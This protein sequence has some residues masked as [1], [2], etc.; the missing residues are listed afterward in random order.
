MLI[1][2]H[3]QRG[4]AA[5]ESADSSLEALASLGAVRTWLGEAETQAILDARN[6]G[7]TLSAIA[8]ALGTD[9]QNVHQKLLTASRNRGLSHPDF[10]GVT[11][12]TL[13]YWY[14][15]WS[16]DERT[17]EGALEDGRDP[18]AEA[19]KVRRE[20]DARWD[21]GLLRKPPPGVVGVS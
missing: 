6:H 20:L 16:K 7:A 14:D 11:S 8:D 19:E 10:D 15:W 9:R 18:H 4:F 17:S 1:P 2:P 13:R 12:S 3:I 5:I 21:A